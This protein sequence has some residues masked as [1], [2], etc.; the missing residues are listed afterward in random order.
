MRGLASYALRGACALLVAGACAGGS[1]AAF[2]ARAGEH[3]RAAA[4]LTPGPVTVPPELAALEQRMAQFHFN[5]ERFMLGVEETTAASVLAS[6]STV[7]PLREGASFTV[8]IAGQG[9]ASLSPPAGEFTVKEGKTLEQARLTGGKLYVWEP[10]VYSEDGHRPWVSWKASSPSFLGS[11]AFAEGSLPGSQGSYAGLLA[12]IG[13][14]QKIEATGPAV[15]NGQSTS[16]FT[17]SLLPAN[18]LTG[19]KGMKLLQALAK[20]GITSVSLELFVT[21]SG[22]PARVR[23]ALEGAVGA[24]AYTVD[25]LALEVPVSVTAPP[26][27][28]TITRARLRRI[29]A[30][31]RGCFLLPG[32]KAHRTCTSEAPEQEPLFGGSG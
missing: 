16:G 22:L 13:K 15:I 31:Q 21:A 18:L 10:S 3:A 25:V 23:V 20:G 26:A 14:A 2:A 19:P 1:V 5:S 28:K 9:V 12:L 7:G 29:Q 17:L 4:T 30:R 6:I 11:T 32:R 27:K 8:A 24:V